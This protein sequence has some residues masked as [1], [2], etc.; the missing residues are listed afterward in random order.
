MLKT[1]LIALPVFFAIDMI[2]LALIAKGFYAQHIGFLM[3]PNINWLAAVIFYIIFVFGLTVFVITPALDKASW[4]SAL[5]YGAL[6]GLVTYSAYDLTNLATLKDWPI[7]VT[8]VD[9]AWGSTI[10]ALVST[11]TYFAAQKL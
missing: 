9:L 7:L 5:L 6:F 3:T 10:G 4:S 1:Y 11:I 8:L 2:W